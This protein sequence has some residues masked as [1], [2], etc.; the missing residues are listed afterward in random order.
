LREAFEQRRGAAYGA[1]DFHERFMRNGA[2]VG[3]FR[4]AF[5]DA[6]G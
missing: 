1:R 5:L 6:P 4:D 3:Y 2:I